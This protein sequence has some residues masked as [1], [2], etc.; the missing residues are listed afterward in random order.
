MCDPLLANVNKVHVAT[1]RLGREQVWHPEVRRL[2]EHGAELAQ[3]RIGAA[4]R[5]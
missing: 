3:A 4:Q 2:V 5:A 1:L